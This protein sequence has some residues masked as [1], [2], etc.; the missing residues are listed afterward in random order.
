MAKSRGSST[1][2]VSSRLASST[3]AT[4][5]QV[6]AA[7]TAGVHRQRATDGAGHA[8]KKFGPG[9]IVHRGETSELRACHAGFLVDKP[10]GNREHSSRRMHQHYRSADASIANQQVAAETDDG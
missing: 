7:I 9:T 5:R 2:N 8:G 1:A 10:V 6:S 3:F 4:C